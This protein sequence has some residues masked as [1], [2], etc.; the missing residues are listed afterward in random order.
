MSK[1]KA[2][3]AQSAAIE[4]IK[5][6]VNLDSKVSTVTR[7]EGA[8]GTSR[9]VQFLAVVDGSVKDISE[10]VGAALGFRIH[11]KHP[12]VVVNG[13]I[14]NPESVVASLASTVYGDATALTA[15]PL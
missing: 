11:A 9:V 1:V 12:G 10:A 2:N 14:Y 4:L 6:I 15:N 13:L 8:N 7:Y 5:S 3:A